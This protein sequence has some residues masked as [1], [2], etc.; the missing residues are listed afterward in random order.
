MIHFGVD[1]DT[2]RNS[3][4]DASM[5]RWPMKQSHSLTV[6]F[7]L[8][9]FVGITGSAR[10]EFKVCNQTIGLYNVAIGAEIDR[11]FHTEGWWALP[12]NSCVIPIKEDLDVLQLRYVYLHVESVTGEGAIDGNWDMCVDSKRFKIER[13][14]GEPWNCWV[15]G[16]IQTRFLEID[17][18]EAKTW[19]V[20][21]R[22]GTQ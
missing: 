14:S 10:S 9:G 22:P 8:F 19:T 16:F 12:A 1:T 11:R 7:A 17:T 5:T 15:R 2:L 18:G 3:V 13:I 6:V 4:L 21:V 20:F